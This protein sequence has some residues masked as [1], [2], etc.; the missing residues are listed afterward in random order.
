MLMY[1][2][3]MLSGEEA[4]AQEIK[5]HNLD[6]ILEEITTIDR[7]EEVMKFAETFFV[8]VYPYKN[9]AHELE[10]NLDREQAESLVSQIRHQIQRHRFEDEDGV[11]ECVVNVQRWETELNFFPSLEDDDLYNYG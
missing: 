9:F 5:T 2:A 4:K 10:I 3:P 7:L 8:T 11:H 6:E 1:Q